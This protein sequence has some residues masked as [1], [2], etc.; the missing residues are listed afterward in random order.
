MPE[1][2]CLGFKGHI[3]DPPERGF[4]INLAVGGFVL[5]AKAV[6]VTDIERLNPPVPVSASMTV[7]INFCPWCGTDLNQFR[8]RWGR[9]G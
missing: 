4:R 1:W 2:C 8:D 7:R 3:E 5:E 6:A 9:S